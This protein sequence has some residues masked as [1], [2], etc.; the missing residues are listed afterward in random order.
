[1]KNL[2]A[3]NITLLRDVYITLM[4]DEEV[5]GRAGM[6]LF[7]KSPEFKAMNVGFEIDEGMPSPLPMI[8]AFYQDKAVWQIRVDCHGIAGHG[9]TLPPTNVTATG[10][11]TLN[12]TSIFSVTLG[13]S[14][15]FSVIEE[16]KAKMQSI[17]C[18]KV[19]NNLFKFRDE[20]QKIA[21]NGPITDASIY[22]SL[23][24]D[25]LSGGTA[26]NVLPNLVSLTFDIRLNTKLDEA[27]F[28]RK[29]E[30]MIN[31]AGEGIDI[32]YIIKDNQSPATLT[33]A[34]NPYWNA[35]TRGAEQIG[36]PII[37]SVASASGDARAVRAAGI[38]ALGMSP[39]PNTPT[40]L[41]AVNENLNVETFL[42]GISFY[43]KIVTELANIPADDT[44]DPSSYLV[45]T[46]VQ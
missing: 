23:N 40:F 27:E 39:M 5:G 7:C 19:I 14:T 18:N 45:N 11:S 15:L 17:G 3:N 37:P 31:K 35:I 21:V 32:T 16:I 24:L 25:V 9:S 38:P 10:N 42:F 34:S 28:Q 22:T 29:L 33:N 46:S 36:V 2:K 41:H 30:K 20:Q 8:G 4:P 13:E 44:S 26:N 1:M 6:R 43:E 12:T